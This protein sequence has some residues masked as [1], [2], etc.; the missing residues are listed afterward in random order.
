MR[1]GN[2]PPGLRTWLSLPVHPRRSPSADGAHDTEPGPRFS[3]PP[4]LREPAV[5]A[6]DPYAVLGV[7][8][9]ASAEQIRSAYRR[10][11]RTHHPDTGGG[12]PAMVRLNAAY[13]TLSDPS[14]RARYDRSD[15]GA[16]SFAPAVTAYED[17][18]G[19]DFVPMGPLVHG[20]MRRLPW[21]VALL[22][23]AFLFVFSAYAGGPTREPVRPSSSSPVGRCLEQQPGLDAFVDCAAQGGELVVKEVT[24]GS[25]CPT[26]SV[27]HRVR[28][29]Q[30]TVC[31]R[32]R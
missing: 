10:Q 18:V 23:L 6:D 8:F 3:R 19:D 7:P 27:A 20:T 2:V 13:A 30:Q 31:L 9:D 24:D 22:V 17:E 12:D 14:A 26:G 15:R 4:P 29:Q 11:A 32:S 5:V 28:G 16:A 1:I 21:V 25:A